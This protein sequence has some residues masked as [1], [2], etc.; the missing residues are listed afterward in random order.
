MEIVDV[1]LDALQAGVIPEDTMELTMCLVQSAA[2]A[3]LVMATERQTS[4]LIEIRN[5]RI[6]GGGTRRRVE[7]D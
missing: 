2:T 7:D 5:A 6:D 3:A 4:K 1:G